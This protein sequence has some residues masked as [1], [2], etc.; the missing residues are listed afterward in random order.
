MPPSRDPWEQIA[1]LTPRLH[2]HVSIYRQE[3]RGE[4][5]YVLH[6]RSSGRFLRFNAVA[7]DVIARMDGDRTLAEILHQ[8]TAADAAQLT[9]TDIL[10]LVA[11]LHG[12]ELLRDAF[13]MSVTQ[14]LERYQRLQSQKRR[15]AYMNPLAI[16]IPLFNPDALLNRLVLWARPLFS[17]AGFAVWTLV[18]AVGVLLAVANGDALVRE[19]RALSLSPGYLLSFWALYPLMKA[20]HE[21]GH[22]LAVK[23][24]GGEVHE[25]GINLLV[26]M[27]VPYVDASSAWA[28]RD[29]RKRALTG[30]A[31]ILVELF[32]AALGVI[33]WTSVEPGVVRTAAFNVALI[34]SLSTLLFNGNPLL[35][36]DGYYVL[37]DLIELPNLAQRAGRYWLYL[38][39]RH[40]L[41][42]HDAA[43]P[44]T[45]HGERR[46]LAVYGFASPLYRLF[47][48]FGIALY[49]AGKFMLIGVLLACW[50]IAMQILLPLARAFVFLLRNPR[51]RA[52][53]RRTLAVTAALVAVPV[54][55]LL[56]PLPSVTRVDGVVWLEDQAQVVAATG[57]LVQRVTVA[58]GSAIEAGTTLMEL[59][60]PELR[61]RLAAARA[62]LD[63]LRAQQASE[64]VADR[65]RGALLTEDVL[66]AEA[67]LDKAR[68]DVDALTVRSAVAGRFVLP[69]DQ[70]PVGRYVRQGEVVGY[71]I[72]PGRTIVRA[73]V[74]QSRAGLLRQRVTGARVVLSERPDRALSATL[75]RETPRASEKLPSR[76][77]GRA[78]GGSIALNPA[79]AGGLTAA[80]PW[81]QVDLRLPPDAAPNGIG[82]R[83]YVHLEHGRE[84]VWRQAARAVQQL[85][86]SRLDG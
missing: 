59:D 86:L 35:R 16:R 14:V 36:Y 29:K 85:L 79:D 45:A 17:V 70:R 8:V 1:A 20:L 33:V 9:S 69:G 44:V 50:A 41:G 77:L 5:W 78:G 38:I 11:Q 58:S 21:L 3:Y 83:A 19:A 60:A 10:Q 62:H 55:L 42:L 84:P 71:L 65:V 51:T 43:S 7:H 27:P 22:G 26:L 63:E 2:R 40:L 82:G 54:L 46:W 39:Q 13:P 23:T 34:G 52:A 74:P 73:L 28:F 49:L 72:D 15:R 81:F 6:D 47:I 66:A 64:A 24:W 4:R 53:P 31:G 37:E 68:A 80:E 76:A 57:G 61:A 32:L 48:L 25:T 75:L 18:V 12:A 67:E 56:V 30:A